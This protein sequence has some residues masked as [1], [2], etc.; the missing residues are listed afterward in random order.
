MGKIWALVEAMQ[1]GKQ[2]ANSETWKN[3]GMLSSIFGVFFSLLLAYVPEL[4]GLVNPANKAA[5]ING[6]V[7]MVLLFNAYTH[8]STSKSVGL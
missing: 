4:T 2:L 1:K 8:I 5:I 6:L 7:D 3:A